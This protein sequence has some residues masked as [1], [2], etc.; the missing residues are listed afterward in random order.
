VKQ[1]EA[2]VLLDAARRS[3]RRMSGY[4]NHNV[5]V[6]TPDGPVLVR[7]PVPGAE[8]MDLRIWPESEI[9]TVLPS[10]VER[11]PQLRHVSDEPPFQIHEF[12][13]G[14]RLDEI[15][16]RGEPVPRDVVQDVLNLFRQLGDVPRPDLPPTPDGWPADGDCAGFATLLS[17]V[18]QR[19]ADEFGGEFEKLF[20]ML[21]IPHDPLRIATAGW[22]SL[23][24][25]PFRLVHSDVHRQNIIIADHGPVFLDWELSL[26]GDPLYELA[27]HIHK[28]AYLD[29]ELETLL[30][31]W[32]DAVGADAS[33]SWQQDLPVYLAHEKV[34]SAIVDSVR[35]TKEIVSPATR[36]DRRDVLI[37]KLA[38]KLNAAGTVWGWTDALSPSAVITAITDWHRS[39][40]HPPTRRR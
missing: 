17:G 34:K 13:T 29:D 3:A 28:M 21:G 15:A 23:T 9:L 19:V 35:Y 27:V 39:T 20:H 24:S 18:T 11:I 4:Y 22:R 25:R 2:R 14:R 33:R 1:Q 26:W 36:T 6:D 40:A 30:S 32:G 7:I 8:Q 38:G 37:V 10:H 5:R 31:G 12:V 16:P